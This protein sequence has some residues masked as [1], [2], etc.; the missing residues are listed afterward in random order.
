MKRRQI[1]AEKETPTGGENALIQGIYCSGMSRLRSN[2]RMHLVVF[3]HACA[4]E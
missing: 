1:M 4:T 3:K 2:S